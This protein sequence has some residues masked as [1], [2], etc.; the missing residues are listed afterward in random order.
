M[1]V[2]LGWLDILAS[3]APIRELNSTLALIRRNAQ[4]QAKLIDELLDMNRLVSGNLGWTSRSST[5]ARSFRA[6]SRD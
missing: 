5:S 6:R 3:G 4:L 2:V 1:N